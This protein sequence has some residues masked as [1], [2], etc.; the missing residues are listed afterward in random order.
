[1]ETKIEKTKVHGWQALTKIALGDAKDYMGRDAKRVLEIETSRSSASRQLVSSAYVV[2]E[3]GTTRQFGIGS[4]FR[5]RILVTGAKCTERAVRVQHETA[6]AQLNDIE[7][8]ARA[9]YAAKEIEDQRRA[10]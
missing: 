1:M 2:L 7:A 4:D 10:A 3:C 5:M 9:Y 6:L 8:K